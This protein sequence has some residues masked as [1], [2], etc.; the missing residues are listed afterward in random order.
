M[1]RWP[2]FT[3]WP[4]TEVPQK[5]AVSLFRSRP[6]V[7]IQVT[8]LEVTLGRRLFDRTTRNFV[9]IEAARSVAAVHFGDLG[10]DATG[11]VGDGKAR[12]H[13]TGA[14]GTLYVGYQRVLPAPCH[15][16]PVKREVPR[17]RY[18]GPNAIS[19]RTIQAVCEHEAEFGIVTLSSPETG[20]SAL[21]F[22]RRDV[23]IRLPQDAL[24]NR[25]EM[26]LKYV[27]DRVRPEWF[28]PAYFR[29][30]IRARRAPIAHHHETRL[31]KDHKAV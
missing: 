14:V 13:G 28:N 7:G 18:R 12:L 1:I 20:L 11:G 2:R 27:K 21:L 30:I 23:L 8:K 10:I 26:W 5:S 15:A 22:R 19:P 24:V 4:A 31:H 3:D 16:S 29:R 9:L 17:H 6:A 25:K